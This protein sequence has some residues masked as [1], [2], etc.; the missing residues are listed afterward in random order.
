MPSH[1]IDLYALV[2]G[3]NA[4]NVTE[5]KAQPLQTGTSSTSE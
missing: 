1:Y 3:K 2:E 4:G 5:F